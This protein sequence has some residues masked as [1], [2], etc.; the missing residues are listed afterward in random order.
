M[1]YLLET[2]IESRSSYASSLIKTTVEYIS[3][4]IFRTYLYASFLKHVGPPFRRSRF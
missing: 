1:Y 4:N 2:E 3:I